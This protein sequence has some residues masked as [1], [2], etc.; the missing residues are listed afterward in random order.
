MVTDQHETGTF[1][2]IMSGVLECAETSNYLCLAQSAFFHV[3]NHRACRLLALGERSPELVEQGKMERKHKGKLTK[4]LR[5][6]ATMFI[7]RL[8][9]LYRK[10]FSLWIRLH[11]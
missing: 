9:E 5:A 6:A 10:I 8:T 2:P 11:P 3:P 7:E 4:R 1:L